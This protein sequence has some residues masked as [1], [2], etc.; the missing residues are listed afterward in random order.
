MTSFRAR[1]AGGVVL[2]IALLG[3]SGCPASMT[4]TTDAGTDSGT[5]AIDTGTGDPDAPVAMDAPSGTDGG[6]GDDAGMPDDAPILAALDTGDPFGDAG[7]LGP[8]EWVP[9]DVL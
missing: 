8:P 4:A 1:G 3:L 6:G 7:A 5:G 2:V 9:I